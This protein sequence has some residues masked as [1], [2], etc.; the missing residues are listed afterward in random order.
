MAKYDLIGIGYPVL[1]FGTPRIIYHFI[2]LI[3]SVKNT[4]TFLFKT[5]ADPSV[6]NN[7]ASKRAIKKLKNKGYNV[8]HE[9]LICMPCNWILKY[10]DEFSKQ[11]YNT[12]KTKDFYFSLSSIV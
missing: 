5:A 7:G 11:L 9:T 1:G 8:F 3:P 4:K 6:L 10:C 2:N 12:A